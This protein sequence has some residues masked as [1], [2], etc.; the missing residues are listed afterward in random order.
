MHFDLSLVNFCFYFYVDSSAF[1]MFSGAMLIAWM[2]AMILVSH[3]TIKPGI[4]LTYE[5]I[6]SWELLAASNVRSR[7][8]ALA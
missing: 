3:K 4:H 1:F 6:N 7:M 2:G 5:N 8:E